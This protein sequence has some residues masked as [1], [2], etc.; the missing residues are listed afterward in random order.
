VSETALFAYGSLVDPASA[1]MTLGRAVELASIA[2][3]PGWRRGWTVARDNHRVEKT[4]A[5]ADDDS[6]PDW[7]LGLNLD[8]AGAGQPGPNG[9][10]IAVSEA[11]LARLDERELRYRRTDVTAA[12]PACDFERVVA[13]T[14]RPEHHHPSA[15]PGAVVIASYLRT[16]EAAFATLGAAE[17]QRFRETTAPPP[18][19]VVEGRLV[20]DR[21]P[22]GNPREW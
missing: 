21:I 9:A 2:Q 6:T 12:L 7:C 14:A 4:F 22:P 16:V 1:A 8:P 5:R 15:P 3:L 13:Y 19:E 20:R 18:A 10:L 17:L 11:D